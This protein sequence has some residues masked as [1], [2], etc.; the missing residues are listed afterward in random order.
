MKQTDI[1]LVGLAVMGQNLA[2][3]IADHGFGIAVYNRT[4]STMEEFVAKNPGTP[5]GIVG[6]GTL[7]E[8]VR[9]IRTPRK[10]IILVKAGRPTDAV[11]DS[12]EPL[13]EKGDIIVDGGN[14]L[15]TDTVRREKA[16]AEKGLRFIGSGVSGGEEG[17]RFGP[18]LMPGGDVSSWN[19][20]E[21]IWKAIAAKVDAKTGKPIEGAKPGR[22][23]GGGVPCSAH[24]GPNGAGHF[25]KMVH[26]GIEYGDM[27]LI[28]EAY[29]ILKNGLG[30]D[31][32]ELHRTF[33]QWNEGDLDSFLIEITANILGT[34]DPVTGKS[35]V[36]VIMDRAGQKGTGQ[37]TIN[38]A[39]EKGVPVSTMSEAVFARCI[40]AIKEE[41]VAASRVIHGPKTTAFDGDRAELVQ[42]VRDSLHASKICSYAQGFALMRVVGKEQGWNL[43]FGEIAMIW[44]GGCIIRARF[45]QRIKE[46]F[47][48]D[49]GLANLLLDPYFKDIIERKQQNWRAIVSKA[50]LAGI[51]VP[52]F[53]ASLAY[54][55]SYRSERLPANLLQAQRDYFGSHTYERVD[56]PAGK[57]FHY[58]WVGDHQQHE[59]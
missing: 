19:E 31:E 51:P 36:D 37:W 48:N 35:F 8:F 15:W 46:A 30:L 4:T 7:E 9:S 2:L 20:I 33:V 41:R 40:S 3:N 43:H 13:L 18:S 17:A 24:I 56:Q 45:L 27:Q 23:V 16:L 52:A 32:E 39:L 1:G 21:P 10:I 5:G 57:F 6:C 28:C 47:D 14:A 25:V 29:S 34:K 12:L 59:V 50:A 42:A 38:A 54:F 53:S 11:I 22:P 44:R 58:D 55:D 26:N 49:P